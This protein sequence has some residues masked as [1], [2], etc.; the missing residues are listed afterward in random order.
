MNSIEDCSISASAHGISIMTPD[1][2]RTIQSTW[3]RVLPIK[4]VAAQIFYDKLFE[5]DPAL[6]KLF[7]NDMTVQG[8]KL[9]QIIDVAV[10]GLN[11]LDQVIP[12]VQELGRR[13]RFYGVKA[14][15][16]GSVGIALLWTLETGLGSDFTQQARE[17]W[18]NV[19][20]LM[21]ST[22]KEAVNMNEG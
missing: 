10:N 2:I 6:R 17:A 12:A 3:L 22:M 8:E 11:R 7:R 9:M 1:Q 13:H 4:A 15:H 5:L 21:A 18:A 16:F 20:D 19:Y 14:H